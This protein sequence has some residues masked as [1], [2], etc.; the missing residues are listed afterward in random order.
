[1]G[2]YFHVNFVHDQNTRTTVIF[3]NLFHICAAKIASLP[4]AQH[5]ISGDPNGVTHYFRL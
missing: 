3:Q 5:I 1:M 2:G 4:R